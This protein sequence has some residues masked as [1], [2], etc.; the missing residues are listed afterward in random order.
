M[1]FSYFNFLCFR[2]F[3]LHVLSLGRLQLPFLITT[4]SQDHLSATQPRRPRF[5]YY[6]INHK[7]TRSPSP[8]ASLSRSIFGLEVSPFV[9]RGQTES[10]GSLQTSAARASTCDCGTTFCIAGFCV[11][12]SIVSWW[13]LD[14]PWLLWRRRAFVLTVSVGNHRC[15]PTEVLQWRLQ[16]NLPPG[17]VCGGR[18]LECIVYVLLE[19]V[20][21]GTLSL[22][23]TNTSTLVVHYRIWH[24]QKS[25]LTYDSAIRQSCLTM[26]W[27]CCLTLNNT[28]YVDTGTYKTIVCIYVY[29]NTQ[30][31]S[32]PCK[33]CA[34]K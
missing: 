24:L 11:R 1:Y 25:S 32:V 19:R 29:P 18:E 22:T 33:S 21:T 30:V 3:L 10:N 31:E 26:C 13:R 28:W 12:R 8:Y 23:Q 9:R 5:T 6:S 4:E 17:G 20:A 7:Y 34:V 27:L 2:L 14:W 16:I 15:L